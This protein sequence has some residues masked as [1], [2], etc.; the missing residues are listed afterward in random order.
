MEAISPWQTDKRIHLIGS[1]IQISQNTSLTLVKLQNYLIRQAG[2]EQGKRDI[3]HNK[4]GAPLRFIFMTTA[5][6][7]TRELIQQVLQ[8][9]WRKIGIDARIRNEPPRVYFGETI[10]KRKF[11]GLAMYAWL[12]APRNIP[13]STLHSTM[14]PSEKN[15]WSG[16]NYSGYNNRVLDKILDEIETVCK[17]RQNQKLWNRLQS[18]YSTELPALPLYFRATPFIFPKWLKGIRPTGHQYTTTL[19]VEEWYSEGRP[20]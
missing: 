11:K 9:Q 4:L 13:R 14:I 8:S 19:W 6:N 12:S 16:Q 10:S 18:I 17:P 5:G 1:I 15:G 7:K 2:I 20:E 3:R